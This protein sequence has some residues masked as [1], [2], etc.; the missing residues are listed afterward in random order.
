[1]SSR[2]IKFRGERFVSRKDLA[3]KYDAH[4]ANLIRRLNEGWSTSQALGLSRAPRRTA[5]NAINLDTSIGKFSSAR[6]A[7]KATKI[8]EATIVRRLAAGWSPEEA[9]GAKSRP[10]RKPKIGR[11]VVCEGRVF[12]SVSNFADHYG[13]N[14][15]RTRKRLDSKWSPEESVG[16]APRPPRYRDQ[17]GAA[18]DHAWTDKQILE[19]GAILPG[20]EPG[21]YQ[22]YVVRD[23]K[24]G[25]EYIG[26]T[27]GNLKGR[28]RGH[29]RSVTT[30]RQS[31][32]HNAMRK[33]LAEE[34]KKDFVIE[35]L[36]NDAKGPRELQLQEI[37]AIRERETIKKGFNTSEG[38]SIGTSKPIVVNE[39]LFPSHQAAADYHGVPVHRF[40]LRLSRLDFS[41]EEAAGLV[42]R[43]GARL[44]VVVRGKTYRSLANVADHFSVPYKTAYARFRSY[45]WSLEQALGLSPPPPKKSPG[46]SRVLSTAIGEFVSINEAA[47]ATGIKPGTISYRLGAGWTPDEAVGANHPREP[48]RKRS[49]DGSPRRK[50]RS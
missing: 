3:A 23:V 37:E 15:I 29:W 44:E 6:D 8:K 26:I 40:N 5:H 42:K 13:Q 48:Q 39:K 1:M 38:G 49:C 16:I 11:S 34:R 19:D 43:K 14:R 30:G 22:L 36:R 27:T 47:R 10:K 7:A 32:F 9:V 18:R 4:Y 31:R 46:N 50:K 45:G 21:H 28:L 41:P 24:S 17:S 20:A 25:K 2:E 12:P 33:A 35:L